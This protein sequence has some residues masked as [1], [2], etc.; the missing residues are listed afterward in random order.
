MPLQFQNANF[1]PHQ[2]FNAASN[3]L[4]EAKHSL[5]TSNFPHS[6]QRTQ[7]DLAST[8]GR[9]QPSEEGPRFR[10]PAEHSAYLQESRWSTPLDNTAGFA[11][12]GTIGVEPL[13]GVPFALQS[14]DHGS[15]SAASGCV[16]FNYTEP[17][18][19]CLHEELSPAH[20]QDLPDDCFPILQS[21]DHHTFGKISPRSAS[22]LFSHERGAK[23]GVEGL[24][25]ASNATIRDAPFED[26]LG[27][28][29]YASLIYEALMK[30]PDHRLV[31]RDI[32]HWIEENTDKAND[33]SFTGWQNSVRHNLSMNEVSNG[34]T[35]HV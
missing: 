9:L 21:N 4:F 32:Y 14:M 22:I 34:R 29:S 11:W 6:A 10:Q 2:K 25:D 5:F 33:P 24:S 16:S 23:A 8:C 28:V 27:D 1:H 7:G 3:T 12:E 26:C 30:A 17:P 19:A 31:L 35:L 13:T 20:Y 15:S 18:P